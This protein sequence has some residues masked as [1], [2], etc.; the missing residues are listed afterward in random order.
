MNERS[1]ERAPLSVLVPVKNEAANLHDC[2][3]S[4]S[5][6]KEIVM[7]DSESTD[8]T[9]AIA[10]AAGGRI[11][12]PDRMWHYT[13][14]VENW[15]PIWT[16]STIGLPSGPPARAGSNRMSGMTFRTATVSS[17]LG[18]FT[19]ANVDI[20]GT[21]S[22]STLKRTRTSPSMSAM[23]SG[24]RGVGSSPMSRAR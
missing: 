3:A 13:E 20:T 4:V 23:R 17:G 24:T 16:T 15:N 7:V 19:T 22:V 12:N 9:P 14:G 8:G 2:L 21:P 10:E 18:E 11:I 5:F 1:D 6:A